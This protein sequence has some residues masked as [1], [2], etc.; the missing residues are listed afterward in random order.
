MKSKFFIVS[1]L[2][3]ILIFSGLFINV[4]NIEAAPHLDDLDSGSLLDALYAILLAGLV[5]L[6][7]SG[8]GALIIK[9][10]KSFFLDIC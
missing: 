1:A 9:P 7:A 3:L 6:I 5:L 10:F 8:L 2:V 4:Q